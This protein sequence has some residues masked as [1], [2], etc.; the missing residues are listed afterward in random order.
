MNRLRKWLIRKLGGVSP[1]DTRATDFINVIP[2][3]LKPIPLRCDVPIPYD[4]STDDKTVIDWADRCAA[5]RL[6][7]LIFRKEL[8]KRSELK[9]W[10][11]HGPERILRYE[12][13]VMEKEG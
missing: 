7:E 1:S 8:I 3:A 4:R 5:E 13:I 2:V 9:D 10:G 12:L 6:A 11:W